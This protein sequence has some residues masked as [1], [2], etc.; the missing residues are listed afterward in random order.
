MAWIYTPQTAFLVALKVALI[1]GTLGSLSGCATV[2]PEQERSLLDGKCQARMVAML[3]A[4]S[5]VVT[6]TGISQKF[7]GCLTPKVDAIKFEADIDRVK[8][9]GLNPETLRFVTEYIPT[10][11][12]CAKESGLWMEL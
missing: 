10:I 12:A 5:P 2:A 11:R 4:V 7:C 3:N 6:G 8:D 1:A 9:I